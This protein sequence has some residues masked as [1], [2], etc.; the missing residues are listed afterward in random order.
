[1]PLTSTH[2]LVL[3]ILRAQR[4]QRS[5]IAG[6]A[7]LHRL[8]VREIGDIDIHHATDIEMRTAIDRDMQLLRHHGFAVVDKAEKEHEIEVTLDRGS[9]GITLNWVYSSDELLFPLEP[10]DQLGWRISLADAIYQKLL[11]VFDADEHEHKHIGD[12]ADCL[13]AQ[14]LDRRLVLAAAQRKSTANPASFIARLD[15]ALQAATT[16]ELP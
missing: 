4:T 14:A 12:L 13:N 6:S 3:S 16:R 9:A 10:D 15:K 7:V 8:L 2:R 11:M 5:W 1:M